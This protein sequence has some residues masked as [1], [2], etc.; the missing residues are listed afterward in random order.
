MP[1]SDPR[2]SA[3]LSF[4]VIVGDRCVLLSWAAPNNTGG[5]P[6]TNYLIFRWTASGNETMLSTP[7]N[8]T[9]YN[10]TGL[11]NG[12]TY[13]Y[14]LAAIN[15]ICM[16]LNS[17]ILSATPTTSPLHK[18][19]ALALVFSS[20]GTVLA[21]PI[22]VTINIT[23]GDWPVQQAWCIID[24][25]TTRV[26][27]RA[28]GTATWDIYAADVNLAEG[29]HL[30]AFFVQDTSNY[31]I[32][33]TITITVI[34]ATTSS[35][36]STMQVIIVIIVVGMSL[37]VALPVSYNRYKHRLLHNKPV[38]VKASAQ[39]R[40][41]AGVAAKTSLESDKRARLLKASM[42]SAST[43]QPILG[44]NI[45]QRC[46]LHKGLIVGPSMKCKRCGAIYCQ[47][48]ARQL[49]QV[50]EYCFNCGDLLD[51]V[52]SI[53]ANRRDMDAGE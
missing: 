38:M 20:H 30:L 36:D 10:D 17:T 47:D 32:S 24:N 51:V 3:P 44:V 29:S 23:H 7:W 19:L 48:C 14:K 45:A 35:K 43:G 16:G 4:T 39:P 37:G 11:T 42:P 27:A 12:V 26:L 52:S 34:I 9:I 33:Q 13:Y 15:G 31:T 2:P 18:H 40:S 49:I 22:H 21:N 28:N 5:Y 41:M 50:D 8:V 6:I 53:D 25:S 1:F 46:I